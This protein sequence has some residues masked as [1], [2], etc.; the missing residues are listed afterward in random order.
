MHKTGILIEEIFPSSSKQIITLVNIFYP[1]EHNTQSK[2]VAS[3]KAL[4]YTGASMTCIS[5]KLE[6]QLSLPL[7]GSRKMTSAS[8]I[9]KTK[10]YLADIQ[11]CKQIIV[12]QVATYVFAGAHNFDMLIGMDIISKGTFLVN[13]IGNKTYFSFIIPAMG[14]ASLS[15]IKSFQNLDGEIKSA[16]CSMPII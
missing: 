8:G 6:K 1:N 14:P 15:A 16:F 3:V 2:A 5:T 13:T 10:S 4:W 11:I 9:T 7:L 12:P